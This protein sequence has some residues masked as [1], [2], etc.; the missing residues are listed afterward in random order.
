MRQSFLLSAA[1]VLLATAFAGCDDYIFADN[2][3]SDQPLEPTWEGVSLFFEGNCESCHPSLNSFDLVSL[4][5]DVNSGS[6]TYVVAG[7]PEGSLLWRVLIDTDEFTPLMPLGATQPIPDEVK[8]HVRQW[9]A[10]GASL[11]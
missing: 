8:G 11:E 1:A 10:D 5:A 6:G 7:D 3:A 4:Q 2:G 9:I